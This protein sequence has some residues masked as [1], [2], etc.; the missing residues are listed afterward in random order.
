[1]PTTNLFA[2]EADPRLDDPMPYAIKAI[3]LF[4]REMP[5][6]RMQFAIGK[7]SSNEEKAIAAKQRR[8]RAI[9][10]V[11]LEL[12]YGTEMKQTLIA[13]SGDRPSFGWLDKRPD[14]SPDQK[15]KDLIALVEAARTIYLKNGRHFNSP[16][17]LW[18]RCYEEV[19][20]HGEAL[21]HES[22]SASYASAMFERAVID[23]VCR[24][25]NTSFFGM[26]KED[27]LGIVPE[28]VHPELKGI[29]LSD[30]L[31][32][33]PRTRF[34]IRHTVGL[35]DPITSDDLKPEDRVN[36]GEPETLKEYAQRDGLKYFKVK[37]SGD[38]EK[39]LNRLDTIWNE[40]LIHLEE[41]AITLDGNEAYRDLKTF[42]QFVSDFE[43]KLPGLFQHTLFIEQPLTRALTHDPTTADWVKAI[44]K[45]KPLVI[46]EADGTNDSFKKAFA[47]GYAGTSH[48][49]C[50]GVFKSLLNRALCFYF[51]EQTGRETFLT[52][53]DLSNMPIVPIH[54][55]FATLSVLDIDHCERNGHHYGFGLSHLTQEEK[56]RVLKNHPDLYN[57]RGNEVFLKIQNGEVET[58]SLQT[59]G[60]GG[61]TQPDWDELTPLD[62]WS[63]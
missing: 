20:A 44:A 42:A 41:P 49:N 17:E 23:A 47:I 34:S 37:I 29:Q 53:E 36:D 12:A 22:L 50:K 1:M 13:C 3:D 46:D 62:D 32:A 48:K 59:P 51:E 60:F 40:V 11:R 19:A 10:L 15:L 55:D 45:R 56:D 63:W 30:H 6:N 7:S 31:P 38:P 24:A 14:R 35:A 28:A 26:V 27:K 16:F 9:F 33:A 8:P 57:R 61:S 58:G 4:V 5:A 21:G 39:D 18:H 25:E 2:L 52:G 54:Q 43:V